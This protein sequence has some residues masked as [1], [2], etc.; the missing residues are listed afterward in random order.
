MQSGLNLT[1][2]FSL[3]TSCRGEHRVERKNGWGERGRKGRVSDKAYSPYP[4]E[5]YE[6]AV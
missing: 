4:R 5:G 2:R 3:T 1:E 6:N